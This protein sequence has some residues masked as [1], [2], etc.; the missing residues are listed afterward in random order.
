MNISFENVDKVSALLTLNIEKAD[1][2]GRVATEIKNAGKKISLPG[3]RP[4]HVPAGIIKKRFG[5]EILAEEI[6]K[7]INE[8]VTKYIRENKINML[9]EPLPNEEKTPAVDFETQEAFAFAFDIALAPEFDAKISDKDKVTYYDIT[10]SDELVEQQINSFRQR[11]GDRETA[12]EYQDNDLVKGLFT[13]LDENGNTLEGGITK[14]G[15]ILLPAYLK[16]EDEKAKFNGAKLGDILTINPAKAS[17]G[18]SVEVASML[19]IDKEAAE[20]LTSDFSFQINEISRPKAAELNQEFFDQILGEGVV[21]SEEEFRQF[22]AN[23]IKVNFAKQ[24][25]FQFTQDLRAYLTARIGEVEYP[26]A[27]LKRFMKLR[28]QD[29]DD[30]YVE[31]N[32]QQSLTE[33]TWHLCKEQIC[34]QLDVKVDQP[35][36]L[37]TAKEVT[38]MQFAQYG[39]MNIPD[40]AIQNYAVEMLKNEGQAQALVER[41]VETKMTAAAKQVVTIETKT[42]TPDEFRA[43]VQ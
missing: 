16:D 19:G 41:T 7:I 3:F 26:E 18:S 12:E 14:E 30:E 21:K 5:H 4:G 28:N 38:R 17:A 25:D 10:V 13:Q 35:D 20:N 15:A 23:D 6:N 31:N 39:M 2:E 36:V 8:E 32:F 22:I 33:L 9:A 43:I 1:Y 24:S 40:E 27:I 11:G 34:D 37:D 29:K 42:V